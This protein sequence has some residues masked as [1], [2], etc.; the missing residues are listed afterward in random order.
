MHID[1]E[2][3]TASGG[4][5]EGDRL[6]SIENVR[7]SQRNDTLTG[8]GGDNELRGYAG[9]DV[10]SGGAGADTLRG[11]GGADTLTG[12][13]GDDVF[14]FTQA[15]ENQAVITDFSEGDRLDL[16]FVES[17]DEISQRITAEGLVVE[18]GD[19]QVLLEGVSE[20][21]TRE[22]YVIGEDFPI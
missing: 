12:G 15:S 20:M 9:D 8:D 4:D 22:D 10:L 6:V 19:F 16:A 11:D 2:A 18:A 13:A 3:G 5:A 14:L 7:G 21:L 1:L 17:V